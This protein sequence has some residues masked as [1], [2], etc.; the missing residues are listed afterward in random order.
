MA[1]SWWRAVSGVSVEC[2][3]GNLKY[4]QL[5]MVF[6]N[7]RVVGNV[8]VDAAWTDCVVAGRLVVLSRTTAG[9][10]IGLCIEGRC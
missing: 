4:W 6:V 1:K 5:G 2:Y 8:A 7:L 9:G 3:S 10:R